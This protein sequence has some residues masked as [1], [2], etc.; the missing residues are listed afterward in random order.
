MKR[1]LLTLIAAM[2][3][4]GAN[5]QKIGKN[6][7]HIGLPFQKVKFD[8]PI[9]NAFIGGKSKEG[10]SLEVGRTFFINNKAPILDMIR[11]GIDW[12][13]LDLQGSA[14]D[15]K[16]QPN[17]DGSKAKSAYL[18]AGMQVGPSVTVSPIKRLNCKAYLR[19]APS[20]VYFDADMPDV[21][22]GGYAGFITTGVSVSYSIATIG[23]ESRWASTKLRSFKDINKGEK[24]DAKLPA[25]RLFVG[26]RF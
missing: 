2:L 16:M 23:F 11:I 8:D 6:Y 13:Y 22:F 24:T 4:F 3:L 17:M 15:S 5:A 12:S 14:Y 18:S 21:S 7:I 26:F 1:S 10:M 9:M 19:Y 25:T 20:F